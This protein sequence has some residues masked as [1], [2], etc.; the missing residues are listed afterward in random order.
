MLELSQ[1][2]LIFF[3]FSVSSTFLTPFLSPR[4]INSTCRELNSYHENS[5]T[6]NPED[7]DCYIRRPWNFSESEGHSPKTGD[8]SAT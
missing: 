2:M 1:R 4:Y 7:G 8:D 3:P 5:V 6:C